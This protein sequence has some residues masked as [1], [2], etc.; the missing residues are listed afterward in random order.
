[1]RQDGEWIRGKIL[2]S[3]EH[4]VVYGE[5]ALVAKVDLGLRIS[6]YKEVKGIVIDV[7]MELSKKQLKQTK[8]TIEEIKK[9]LGYVDGVRVRIRGDLP[10]GKGMGS[11]AVLVVGVVKG[12]LRLKNKQLSEDELFRV[13]WAGEN[14]IHGISSGADPAAVLGRGMIEYVKGGGFNKLEIENKVK[15]MVVDTGKPEETTKDMVEYVAKKINERD[16]VKELVAR[17]GGVTIEI[18]KA[19][20][21]GVNLVKLINNNGELLEELGVV[22]DE[23]I[24]VSKRLRRKGLGVKVSGA[25]GLTG[26][27]GMLLMIGNF[28][29]IK[30]EVMKL[31]WWSKEVI[32]GG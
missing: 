8:K 25:G 5:P 13:V 11:S 12:I 17:I 23:V 10:I 9:L 31:G 14:F 16:D 22:N 24:R 4:S 27:S 18:K 3:G 28:D 29:V 6:V 30:K 1:M 15:A 20:I 7:S 21:K 26:G 32:I 2:I 19:L